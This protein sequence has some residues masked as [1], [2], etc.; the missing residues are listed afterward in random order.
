MSIL[1][2]SMPPDGVLTADNVASTTTDPNQAPPGTTSEG[3]PPGESA[4]PQ[5]GSELKVQPR[6]RVSSNENSTES[7]GAKAPSA[8]EDPSE[9]KKKLYNVPMP[10]MEILTIDDQ[11]GLQTE[12]EK[13]QDKFLDLVESLKTGRYLTDTIQGVE[14]DSM[15]IEP[16]AVVYHGDYKVILMASMVVKLPEDLRGQSPNSVYHYLLSR[17]LGAEIDYVIKGIDTNTGIAVGSRMEA[18]ANKRR[19]YFINTEKDGTYRTYKGLCCECRVLCVI[20]SGI[21][22]E[23]FGIDVFIPIRELSYVRI[24]DAM[25]H[26]APGD[27]ILAKITRLKRDDPNNILVNASV[28]QVYENPKD[29][30]IER[31]ELFGKYAGTVT[32][33]DIN[34]IFV[35]LDIGLDCLCDY[36]AR[37]R[38]PKGSQ[39]IVKVVGIDAEKKHVSGV[40]TF[41][42]PPK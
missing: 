3:R 35:Q 34:G 28:K 16:R 26:F 23:L 25:E 42:S 5:T 39:V 18:M 11:L 20:P 8:E 13:A 14:R 10:G 37:A 38:P 24:T 21:F 41:I 17:R 40:I 33:L 22:V 1:K 29:K 7:D 15:G 2:K 6:R 30:A 9:Q 32:M 27:R 4:S 31:I 19:H 12:A 36:P